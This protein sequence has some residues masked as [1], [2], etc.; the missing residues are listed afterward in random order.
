VYYFVLE[1]DEDLQVTLALGGD[2]PFSVFSIDRIGD[3]IP[4]LGRALACEDEDYIPDEDNIGPN[5]PAN[6]LCTGD[7]WQRFGEVRSQFAA[8]SDISEALR[9]PEAYANFIG[10]TEEPVAVM[11]HT[12]AANGCLLHCVLAA[13]TKVY[14]LSHSD[15]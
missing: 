6:G 11:V 4:D 7:G 2:P 14:S 12:L 10:I 3:V 1:E 13:E 8:P 9:P 5:F 15:G